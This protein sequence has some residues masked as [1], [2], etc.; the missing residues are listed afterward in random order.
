MVKVNW[1]AFS[2]WNYHLH[3]AS[4]EPNIQMAYSILRPFISRWQ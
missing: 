2:S 3:G 4:I 1:W